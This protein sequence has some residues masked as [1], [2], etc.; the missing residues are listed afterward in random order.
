MVKNEKELLEAIKHEHHIT[1]EITDTIIELDQLPSTGTQVFLNDLIV[2]LY[3]RVVDVNDDVIVEI[4][5]QKVIT[6]DE[7]IGWID[8]NFTTYSADMFK[9][10]I[11]KA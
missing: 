2:T 1:K 3:N 11:G 8:D 7:F 5:D 6:P 10:S 4:F 9:K